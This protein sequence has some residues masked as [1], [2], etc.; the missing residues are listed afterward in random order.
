[1]RAK[2]PDGEYVRLRN[3]QECVIILNYADGH[4]VLS[5]SFDMN[6]DPDPKLDKIIPRS[7]FEKLQSGSPAVRALLERIEVLEA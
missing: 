1:M 2:T 6:G 5:P 7:V 3:R 4:I